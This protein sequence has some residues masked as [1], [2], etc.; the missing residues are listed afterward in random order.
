MLIRTVVSFALLPLL[1]AVIYLAPGWALA[2][3]YSLMCA[4]SQYELLYATGL[5]KSKFLVLL[6][7]V[8]AAAVPFSGCFLILGRLRLCALL[9]ALS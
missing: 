9:P 7:A 1:L 8:V 6:S 2:C 4:I 5:I 3:V